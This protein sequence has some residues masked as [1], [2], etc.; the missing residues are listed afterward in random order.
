MVG[1][2]WNTARTTGPTSSCARDGRDDDPD[3]DPDDDRDDDP[4]DD[5]SDGR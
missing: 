5:A 3:D 1:S 4:D 2:V